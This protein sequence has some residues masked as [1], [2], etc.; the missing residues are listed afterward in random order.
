M[1]TKTGII[2]FSRVNQPDIST[3]Y[4]LDDN[5]RALVAACMNF[6]LTGDETCLHDILK[7]L[8]FIRHCIQPGGNFLNYTDKDNRFTNQNLDTNL[9]DSNG[10]AIWALGY[11]I[12]LIDPLPLKILAEHHHV[13]IA[14]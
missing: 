10:R 6:K 1:T 13:Q 4:T 8:G 3:G 9:D 12:S 14:P 7:Y 2:Q 11:V 5:A